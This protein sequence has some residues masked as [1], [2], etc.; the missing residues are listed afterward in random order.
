[1]DHGFIK[2]AAASCEISLADPSANA[3]RIIDCVQANAQRGVSLLVFPELCLT[4]YTCG[5][6][7]FNRTLI[8]GAKKALCDI[9]GRTASCDTVFVIGMPIEVSSK[10]YDCAAVC[11][12]GQV[13]GIVPKKYIGASSPT[14]KYFTPAP[15]KYKVL[16]GFIDDGSGCPTQIPFGSNMI[17][18]SETV[19]NFRFGVQISDDADTVIPPACGLCTAGAK[20][21]ACPS[22]Q[23]RI[24]GA[25]KRRLE[26]VKAMSERLVCGYI[27]AEA[28][29]A[30][31]TQ[32]AVYSPDHIIA[33]CGEILCENP[34]F[35]DERQVL[36]D[37]DV[38]LIAS[39]RMKDSLYQ[40]TSK[41][42]DRDE[43]YLEVMFCQAKMRTELDRSFPYD[44][45]IPDGFCDADAD[46]ILQ[47]QSAGLYRRIKHVAPKTVVLGISG[48]LDSTLALLV[49]YYAAKKAGK[50]PDFITAVTM[51]CFGTSEQT[52]GNAERLCE[53][54]G[55]KLIQVNISNA[56]RGHFADIG[57][58][59]N[60]HDAAFENAQAR[61]RT[62]VLMDIANKDGGFVIGT[63]D[64]SELALGFC[65]YNGD[66]M[67][68]YSVNATV[69]KTLMR[70]MV[71]AEADKAKRN[72]N[73]ALASVLADILDTPISPELLPAK[74][75]ETTQ[76][77]EQIVGPY[78]LHDL[79]IYYSVYLG[80]SKEKTLRI[81]ERSL[82]GAYTAE[83]TEK[84][85]E[86]FIKR[87]FTQ[88]FKR[89]CAP[90][91][92]GA[93]PVSFNPRGDF[94]MPSEASYN[95]FK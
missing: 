36:T 87:F 64:L 7:F 85:Y 70:R 48:G 91:G 43:E 20:I 86:V 16:Y 65:T 95:I 80:F 50:A 83:E 13:L 59:E 82:R 76:K 81:A 93:T 39:E 61:E 49:A 73:D 57:I 78:D 26:S 63:G 44:P 55:V 58:D 12:A 24:S 11:H 27:K 9:L 53:S 14:A 30:E 17:F 31:S 22:A 42:Y 15:E 52:K 6:L 40:E 47:I 29:T 25:H 4:G 38:E 74:D 18:Y 90:D 88:Q 23:P 71:R 51:P 77:T 75:G 37:I 34:L 54:L 8:D 79:F 5:E 69:P 89:A 19:E 10:L 84:W 3:E 2:C 1:M 92:A 56:V 60:V 62:Q 68:M 28:D 67:S 46:E 32:N 66:H 33:E 45:F 35:S 72:G 41:L 21:I 94:S